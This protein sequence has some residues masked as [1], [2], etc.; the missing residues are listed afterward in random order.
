MDTK[1]YKDYYDMINEIG[2]SSFSS[3]YKAKVKDKEEYVALKVINKEKIKTA[4]RNEYSKQN[5]E[6]EYNKTVNFDNEIKFMKICGE[7]N[8]NSVKYYQHFETDNE[9]IIAM[10]LC[11][12]NLFDFIHF[13]KEFN[14]NDIYELLCQLNN[15]FKIMKEKLIAH[16]NLKLQN[17]LFKYENKEK[18]KYIFKISSYSVSKE[19]LSLSQRFSTKVGTINFMAPEVLEGEKYNFKCDLWSLGII[20]YILYFKNYPY[21]GMNELA[22]KKQINNFGKKVLKSSGNKNFDDLVRGLLTSI[23]DQRFNW[24]QYFNH[25]FFENKP[26]DKENNQNIDIKMNNNNYKDYYNMI[27]E[28]GNGLFSSVY[29]AKVKDKEEYVA[30]KVIDKEKIKTALRNEYCKQNI[31][32]EYK[33]A[34]NFDNEIKFMKICGENNENSVKY[35]QHFETD[36][37]FFIIMEL[38][39]GNLIDFIKLKKDLNIDDIYEILCQL[40]NTFKIMKEK[41]IAHR[42]LKLQNILF[43][44]KNKEKT[45]FVFKISSYSVS[46]EFFSSSERF[47]TKVGTIN[48]MAPEVLEGE[49]YNF[50][51]DLWSLGIIIYILYFKNY[52]Y[53][54]MNELALKNQIKNLGQKILKSSG[55]NNFDDLVRGLLTSIPEERFNWEQYFN[56]PFFENKPLD[57]ENNQNIDLKMNNNNYKDYYDIIKE[58]G[59]GL[60]SSVYKAKVKDKEEFVAMKVIDKE[61]I[62]TAIRNE[63]CK[64]DVEKEYYQ[65]ANFD[66]E[67]KFMKICGENN[68]NSV[69]YYKH[70]E[71]N[72]KFVI[73]MELCDGNLID[74]IKLKNDFNIDDIYELLSQLNNTFKI[75][76]QNKIVHRNLKLHK[77]LVKFENEEKTKYTFK[78][79]G[80][81]I[82]KKFLG[83]S[84]GFSTKV[85]TINFMAPEV[86]EGEKYNNE[87]DLWSLGVIIYTLYFKNYPYM[88]MNEIAL[89]NQIKNLGKKVLKRS[90]NKYFDNLIS[91]LLTPIPNQRLTWEQYFN[92]PFFKNKSF[93]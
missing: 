48:F 5:I 80:Y 66:N 31:E 62:K 65:Y 20:I 4:L 56:H 89:K 70:F 11:D 86:L 91:G 45:N 16:R 81:G 55:N 52:P 21:M 49:K 73:I 19:F 13:K 75:M 33:K 26:L 22:L 85:G 25:P 10:E 60:F 18:S 77:I 58:I 12:G 6:E 61:K 40:N 84:E 15:T 38:C 34:T 17:I 50:K 3:V 7:N 57:K 88:G 68:E 83:L 23:P 36:N 71:T 44:Y 37:K 76:N 43:K 78:I 79:S 1:N 27:K 39:D 59:N 72:N 9:F 93:N 53:M 92:H 54:G 46:K 28:I 24:E 42:D 47:S 29:K 35:Y 87:C 41:H 90:G 64:Q 69:K 74:L 32:E 63:Y 30:M 8:E 14:I 2:K 82:S 51:C 67:I